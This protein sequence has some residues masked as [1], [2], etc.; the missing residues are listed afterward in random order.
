GVHGTRV[1]FNATLAQGLV[2]PLTPM[3]IGA[4]RAMSSGFSR[5]TG[6]PTTDPL[7]GSALMVVAA[8]RL[9]L[10]ITGILAN[11][12]GRRLLPRM[13]DVMEARSAVIL[14]ELINDPRFARSGSW[15]PLARRLV[16]VLYR[17]RVPVRVVEGVLRPA[18]ARR[19][20]DEF[21]A[22]LRT[23]LEPPT[24]AP[25]LQRLDHVEHILGGTFLDVMCTVAPVALGSA[26]GM[27][28]LAAGL[29]RGS[30]PGAP[31]PGELGTVLRGLPHNVTTEMD[32]RLWRLASTLRAD[33]PAAAALREQTPAELARA[34]L[35][36]TLPAV[37]Q[38]GAR[39]F[40]RDYGH[41]AVAEID[42]GL[43]RWS[44]D[45]EHI[46]G[47]LAN[48]LRLDDPAGAPDAQFEN[49]RRVAEQTV[50]RL[51][52]AA[53]RRGGSTGRLRGAL[54]G[55]GLGRA[56][57]LAGLREL[58]KYLF[59]EV[60]GAARREL[61]LLGAELAADGRLDHAD[62]V[63]W[64][65]LVELRAALNGVDQRALV[66]PRRADYQAE[67]R[68]RQLPRV[69]LSDGTEPEAVARAAAATDGDLIGTAASA[70][71][72]TGTARVVLDPVGAHLEPGE[73]LVAPSTDPGWT[74]L[75]L[76]AGAL[77]MEM[78]G[79]NS[80]GAV[81]AREYG[82]PAVVGVPDATTRISTGQRITVHGAEGRIT[83]SEA[84]STR[85]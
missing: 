49:G 10:D 52:R 65:N 25:A 13:L 21:G 74:P 53:R 31:E 38:Q 55:F 80:H 40:L 28:G 72:V 79:A 36:G 61:A 81:V 42:L 29:L 27:F 47:V 83:C 69:L 63:F 48:Y 62:D 5:H 3:G 34:Y 66:V 77:V 6:G 45:P 78:G 76:T 15:W 59:V 71:T 39:D 12:V 46:F 1:Y 35:A 4:L 68:R 17:Y 75:F 32:L 82:I 33:P 58:P 8:Q 24:G 70:G 64:L 67:L 18:S 85:G 43:P 30:Y 57:E 84:D 50:A 19:R 54:V 73:I 37:A 26:F 51:V 41:R 20:I 9:L 16:P 7:A 22:Q 44:D 2:R 60:L 14:R 11:P 56:R 23:R